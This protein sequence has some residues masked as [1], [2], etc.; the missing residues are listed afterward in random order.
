MFKCRTLLLPCSSPAKNVSA[1]GSGETISLPDCS[2]QNNGKKRIA[3]I[4]Y[5]SFEQK[6]V[7]VEEHDRS[8]PMQLA[9]GN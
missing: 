8:K 6:A 1:G 4:L 3:S 7:L 9:Q 5:L 2:E